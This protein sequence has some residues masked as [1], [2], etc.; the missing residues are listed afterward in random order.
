[1]PPFALPASFTNFLDQ[2][3]DDGVATTM[4]RSTNGSTVLAGY[5]GSDFAATKLGVDGTLQWQWQVMHTCARF[6]LFSCH[7][8]H[9][10]LHNSVQIP[11]C[12]QQLNSGGTSIPLVSPVLY[13]ECLHYLLKK[14]LTLLL[15]LC[16]AEY[17]KSCRSFMGMW[18]CF[19]SL[20]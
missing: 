14:S 7:T 8:V 9:C 18:R 12:C 20:K 16:P 10:V 1:M 17:C 2:S 11:H 19:L 6:V 4:T 3:D 15:P 13:G 5:K